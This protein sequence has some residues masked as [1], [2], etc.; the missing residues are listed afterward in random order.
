MYSDK[1]DPHATDLADSVGRPIDRRDHR[2]T[3]NPG[4]WPKL[5]GPAVENPR[6]AGGPVDVVP[7]RLGALRP[8]R[9]VESRSLPPKK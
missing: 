8:T 2:G 7:G 9:G 1:H 3:V 6:P 5:G 4:K